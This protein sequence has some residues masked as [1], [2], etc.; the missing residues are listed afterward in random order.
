M[1]KATLSSRKFRPR[2]LAIA[3]AVM[4]VVA[5]GLLAAPSAHADQV[6]YQSV[7]R[8]SAASTCQESTAADLAAG[9]TKW[10]GSWERWMNAGAGGYTC[11]RNIVWAKDSSSS[12][13]GS[14]GCTQLYLSL[15][16]MS[17]NFA[18]SNYLARGAT[19]YNEAT[20]VSVTSTTNI[21]LVYATSLADANVL[22]RTNEGLDAS[23][24]LTMNPNVYACVV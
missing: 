18:S 11:A 7:G 12:Q 8:A 17:V 3:A 15:N 9:W 23:H 4:P 22:C 10:L 1:P 24:Q 6:W 2:V 16:G 19:V 13:A 14:A 21:G 20:C 5:A